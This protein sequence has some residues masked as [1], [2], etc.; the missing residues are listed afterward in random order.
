MRT[1]YNKTDYDALVL[2]THFTE[3]LSLIT[4]LTAIYL[5]LNS[6]ISYYVFNLIFELEYTQKRC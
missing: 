1:E 5:E 2:K 3:F 4:T 6:L